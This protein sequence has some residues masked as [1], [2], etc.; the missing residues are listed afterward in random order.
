MIGLGVLILLGGGVLFLLRGGVLDLLGEG[1][2]VLPNG[3]RDLVLCTEGRVLFNGG[4]GDGVRSGVGEGVLLGAS[5]SS[6]L[7]GLPAVLSVSVESAVVCCC[8]VPLAV[9]PVFC[10]SAVVSSFVSSSSSLPDSES[11]LKSLLG[12]KLIFSKNPSC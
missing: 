9:F 7:I 12:L 1:V 8:V 10:S 3:E 11:E 5:S 4:N 6:N 2:L